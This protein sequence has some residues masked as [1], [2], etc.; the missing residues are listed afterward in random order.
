MGAFL[1]W[2]PVEIRKNLV[3][4]IMGFLVYFL[5]RWSVLMLFLRR[6]PNSEWL[7]VAL[8]AIILV[9]IGFWIHAMQR[10]GEEEKTTTGYHW[11]PEEM[12][13]LKGQL[14]EINDSL[15]R[16]AK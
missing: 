5:A 6:T 13:R 11:N 7:N 16:L 10:A 15:E 2:F 9:C 14:D 4:Y 12:A 8:Y 3:V 1:A